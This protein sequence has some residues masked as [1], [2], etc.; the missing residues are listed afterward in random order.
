MGLMSWLLFLFFPFPTPFIPF[1]SQFFFD[2][3]RLAY[4]H[5]VILSVFFWR[6]GNP[7][8]LLLWTAGQLESSECAPTP[9]LSA[10]RCYV[11]NSLMPLISTF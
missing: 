10:R 6:L 4:S 9:W 5:L 7:H 1:I 2:L 3:R 8:F 11:S